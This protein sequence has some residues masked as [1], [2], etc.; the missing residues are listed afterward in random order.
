MILDIISYAFMVLVAGA[1]VLIVSMFALGFWNGFTYESGKE[2]SK[3]HIW[4]RLLPFKRFFEKNK[5]FDSDTEHWVRSAVTA[6]FKGYSDWMKSNN[7]RVQFKDTLEDITDK[8]EIY[9]PDKNLDS[10]MKSIQAN[11]DEYGIKW[12]PERFD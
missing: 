6:T 12:K 11:L 3:Y 10:L 4:F 9:S 1:Q 5:K 8:I 7:C 2:G